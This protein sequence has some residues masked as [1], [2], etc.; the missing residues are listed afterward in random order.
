MLDIFDHVTVTLGSEFRKFANNTCAA[1]KTRELARE[2][3]ARRR[4]QA[5]KSQES[6]SATSSKPKTTPK[7]ANAKET[8]ASNEN[9]TGRREKSFNLEGYKYHSLG[10]YPRTIRLFGT[11]D[12]YSTE[13]VRW[14]VCDLNI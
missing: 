5:N 8:S 10:D 6:E 12:S 7:P 9:V 4:R 2:A 11:T 1:F 14:T 13:P 3:D